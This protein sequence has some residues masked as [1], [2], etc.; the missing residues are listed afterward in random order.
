MLLWTKPCARYSVYIQMPITDSIK[1][2]VVRRLQDIMSN[3]VK[4]D[5]E[6]KKKRL[7]EEGVI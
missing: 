3:L 7:F 1:S 4:R 2:S 6:D 5:G